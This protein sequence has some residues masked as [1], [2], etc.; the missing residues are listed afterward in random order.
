[1]KMEKCGCAF[2]RKIEKPIGRF[3]EVE[4]K[5]V[6]HREKR[7]LGRRCCISSSNEE[8]GRGGGNLRTWEALLKNV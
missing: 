7:A 1:M 5:Y 2:H 8:G 3:V 6:C 4:P